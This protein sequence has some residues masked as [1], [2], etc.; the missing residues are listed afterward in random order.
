M[1]EQKINEYSDFVRSRPRRYHHVF[2]FDHGTCAA[3]SDHMYKLY[4]L[5]CL[6]IRG[7]RVSE[8]KNCYSNKIMTCWLVIFNNFF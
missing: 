7:R 3:I 8:L 5:V 1:C 2:T 4:T 6:G